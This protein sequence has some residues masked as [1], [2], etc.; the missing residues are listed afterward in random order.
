MKKTKNWKN[1]TKNL[2]PSL[3][4]FLVSEI[5]TISAGPEVNQYVQIISNLDRTFSPAE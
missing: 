1:Q 2:V 3:L 4:I 5:W